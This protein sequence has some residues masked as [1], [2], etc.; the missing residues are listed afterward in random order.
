MVKEQCANGIPLAYDF[1]DVGVNLFPAISSIVRAA[2][3]CTENAERRAISEYEA[4]CETVGD[5]GVGG[6]TVL[7]GANNEHVCLVKVEKATKGKGGVIHRL[8]DEWE[9]FRIRQEK[10]HIVCGER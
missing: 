9:I 4:P 3:P 1:F 2:N 5:A 7:E 8:T 6:T 10:V